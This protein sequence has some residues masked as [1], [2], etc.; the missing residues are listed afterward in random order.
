M[1]A[2]FLTHWM[3]CCG[4]WMILS[5]IAGVSAHPSCPPLE[6]FTKLSQPPGGESSY[7]WEWTPGVWKTGVPRRLDW[8]QAAE[9]YFYELQDDRLSFI[10]VSEWV[11][12][13]FF[14]FSFPFLSFFPFFFIDLLFLLYFLL[15]F[16]GSFFKFFDLRLFVP[17]IQ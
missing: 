7:S 9:E 5:V 13:K 2:S 17:Q 15:V 16:F 3:S 12:N 14:F 6:A 1:D 4:S 10:L 11:Q 8:E